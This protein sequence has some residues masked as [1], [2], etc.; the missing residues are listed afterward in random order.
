MYY[1]GAAP[2]NAFS[3][4]SSH[5]HHAFAMVIIQRTV[6]ELIKREAPK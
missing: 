2:L 5:S 3:S 4:S 1:S 6:R